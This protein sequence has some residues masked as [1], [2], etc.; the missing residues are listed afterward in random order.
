MVREFV[1]VQEGR[2]R[3]E[4]LPACAPELNP[5]EYSGGTCSTLR[6]PTSVPRICGNSAASRGGRCAAGVADLPGFKLSGN[7]RTS[8]TI[9]TILGNTQLNSSI[10]GLE[11][12][13]NGDPLP[14]TLMPLYS[15]HPHSGF[16]V[17]LQRIAIRPDWS[18]ARHPLRST[19][20]GSTPGENVPWNNGTLFEAVP[21]KIIRILLGRARP[22]LRMG[23]KPTPR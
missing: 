2:L 6:G 13:H 18:T 16:N 15:V 14:A 20:H 4:F 3:L 1:A 19:P 10:H 11:A 8:A 7:Q 9:V 23:N 17:L 22:T 12:A 5:T 21:Q